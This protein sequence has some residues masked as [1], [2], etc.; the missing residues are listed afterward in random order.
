MV[1]ARFKIACVGCGRILVYDLLTGLY[2]YT[3]IC[4]CGCK[5]RVSSALFNF[6][7]DGGKE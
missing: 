1:H 7:D 2:W 6:G 4:A 5:L 3:V